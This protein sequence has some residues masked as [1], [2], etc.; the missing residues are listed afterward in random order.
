MNTGPEKIGVIGAGVVGNVLAAHLARANH[1]VCVVDVVPDVIGTIRRDGLRVSGIMDLQARVAGAV[2]TPEE[3]MDFDPSLVV[4]CVKSTAL[5]HVTEGLLACDNGRSVLMSFQN[6]LDT[7]E[8]LAAR[9]PR[10]RVLRG[11]VNYAGAA[12]GPGAVRTTFFHPPNHVG[13][14]VPESKEAADT[15]A[16]LITDAGLGMEHV[17]DIRNKAWRK[18]ILNACLMPISVIT[19]LSMDHIMGLPQTR[20]VVVRLMKD[21]MDVARAEG[22]VYEEDF[23]DN[24]LKYLDG[25]GGH[26]ASMLMDFEA[27]RPL[28]IDFLNGKIQEYA[29][30][31]GVPCEA[32]R[33]LLSMVKGLLLHRDLV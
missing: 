12:I 30:K 32:N 22:H 27:G 33:L 23:V 19:R 20:D 2:A 6:G 8:V 13:C 15:V 1:E 18:A 24:A 5:Q 29:D 16:S 10:E 26:K 3:L 31:H 7:E 25:S 21:F 9:F 14:L 17:P 11:V 28:E 4:I